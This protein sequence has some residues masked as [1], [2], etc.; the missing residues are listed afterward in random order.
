V[1]RR[2]PKLSPPWHAGSIENP[3]RPCLPY[4]AQLLRARTL[5]HGRAGWWSQLASIDD[6]RA[7]PA[8][9]RSL[10]SVLPVLAYAGLALLSA[11]AEAPSGVGGTA[12]RL[13]S[14]ELSAGKRYRLTIHSDGSQELALTGPGFFRNVW[15]TKIVV[16][17]L[18]MR[19]LGLGN[20]EFGAAGEA[21]LMCGPSAPGRCEV[22]IPDSVVR[23]LD[24]GSSA[25][26]VHSLKRTYW[27]SPLETS[28]VIVLYKARRC[29]RR[30]A[31]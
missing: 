12:T 29:R 15:I 19:P 20:I 13:R 26:R 30:A 22:R 10:T 4:H 31:P 9:R 8:A 24:K 11:R 6:L 16:N 5:L 2:V 14:I 18:E 17:P 21:T 7:L 3:R 23:K 28:G 27:H 1:S 25:A